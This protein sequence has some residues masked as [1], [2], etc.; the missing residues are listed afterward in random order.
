[1]P[2]DHNE[3]VDLL[4]SLSYENEQLKQGI[5]NICQ[6]IAPTTTTTEVIVK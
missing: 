2:L 4:N 3:I 6:E 5:D 1:M